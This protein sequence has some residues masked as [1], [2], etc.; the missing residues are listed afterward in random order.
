MWEQRYNALTPLRSEGNTRYYDN[1]QLRRLLN[2]VSLMNANY[3]VSELCE[4]PD[5]KL[6][7]MINEAIGRSVASA[8][9]YEYYISQLIAAGMSY[10]EQHFDKILTNC[11]VRFGMKDAYTK[12][13]YP[14]LVR[15]GLMWC[16]DSMPP[17]NEH[18]MSSLLKQKLFTAIDSLPPFKPSADKWLLFLK[19]TEYHEIGLLFASYL[20]RL[21]G[22]QVIYLGPDVPFESLTQ[23]IK[24]I[25][26][27]Y[28]L[29]FLVH[30]DDPDVIQEYNQ[31]L[32]NVFTGKKI[33]V[34]GDSRLLS[35][36]Q[37]GKKIQWIKTVNELENE[38]TKPNF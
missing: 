3:K 4:M 11:L 26:P 38:L 16:S 25:R 24:T 27:H 23:A 7:S 6:F 30:H 8:D 19:E 17:A 33:F 10:D 1:S 15:T 5:K 13:M 37:T 21:A 28:L 22:K 34:S 32:T 36:V 35:Q 20:I 2:I 18:F 9:P 12:I 31:H 14:M 29:F